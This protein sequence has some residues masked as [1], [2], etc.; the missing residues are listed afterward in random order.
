[1]ISHFKEPVDIASSNFTE[2]STVF[3]GS[4]NFCTGIDNIIN[5][6]HPEVIGIAS[7]CL[8]ETI[9]EDI[10]G[11]IRSYRTRNGHKKLPHFIH[12]ST[13]GY[14]G[15]HMEGFHEAVLSAVK[16]CTTSN[17]RGNNINLFPGFVS[18]ADL[19]HL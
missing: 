19:R 1:M 14:R 3:G 9:G 7:T 17:F 11:L 5:Q 12:A 2:E 13:P 4:N 16:S 8:S 6:Y 10:S 18:R 15:T